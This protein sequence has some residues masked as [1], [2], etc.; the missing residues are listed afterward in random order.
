MLDPRLI[1]P[2]IDYLSHR[3]QTKQDSFFTHT[4]VLSCSKRDIPLVHLL[5]ER[6]I[7]RFH[8]SFVSLAEA[9]RWDSG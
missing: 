7:T 2:S 5:S 3:H 4:G 1:V 6:V 9:Y 8:P